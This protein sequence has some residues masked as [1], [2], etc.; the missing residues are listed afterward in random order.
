MRPISLF[1]PTSTRPPTAS[2]FAWQT[3]IGQQAYERFAALGVT[4]AAEGRAALQRMKRD[5]H[6]KMWNGVGGSVN[7][8]F[9]TAAAA[10]VCGGLLGSFMGGYLGFAV[11]GFFGATTGDGFVVGGVIG[12]NCGTGIGAFGTLNDDGFFA[13][14]GGTL[15]GIGSAILFCHG[16]NPYS[17]LSLYLCCIG[18]GGILSGVIGGAKK[19]LSNKGDLNQQNTSLMADLKAL[20]KAL[21]ECNL[22]VDGSVEK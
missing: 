22:T 16:A 6:N 20:K 9:W 14:S 2:C 13:F 1:S 5:I 7:R 8:G 11:G 18:L 4:N 12:G 21:S 17:Y 15:M 3:A 19:Y 10:G